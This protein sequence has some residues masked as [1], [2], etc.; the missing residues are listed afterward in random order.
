MISINILKKVKADK[1]YP[2]CNNSGFQKELMF[3]VLELEQSSIPWLKFR[4]SIISGTDASV[5]MNANRYTSPNMLWRR[6]LDLAPEVKPSK[7]MILGNI[8]EPIARNKFIEVTGIQIEPAVIISTV[9]PF[10]GASLD[11][12]SPCGT[13]SVE[14]KC[15]ERLFN[16]AMN[17]VIDECYQYQMLHQMAVSSHNEMYYVAFYKGEIC[18]KI[19]KRDQEKID[20]LIIQEKIFY[21]CLKNFTLPEQEF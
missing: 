9:Y 8:N 13:I 6:K 5:I 4:K 11:G 18:V 10:L 16:D 14:I 21:D 3:T 17:G 19:F 1:N 15:S 12:L 2:E 20:E 7:A